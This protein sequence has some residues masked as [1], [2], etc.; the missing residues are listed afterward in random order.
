LTVNGAVSGAGTLTAGTGAVL[1]L[2]G[3]GS[4]SGILG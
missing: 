2:A 1:N 4:F 3:G